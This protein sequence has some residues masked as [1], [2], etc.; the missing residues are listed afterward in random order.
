MIAPIKLEL[1]AI[2]I[3]ATWENKR[4]ID[5]YSWVEKL[6]RSQLG[7]AVRPPCPYKCNLANE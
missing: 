3:L 6:V 2:A 5:P 1:Y 4:L 7:L